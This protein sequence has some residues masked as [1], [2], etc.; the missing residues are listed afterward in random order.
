MVGFSNLANT[1]I[2]GLSGRIFGLDAQF[3]ADAVIMAIAMLVLFTLLSF[4]LF[5]PVRDFLKKRQE[6]VESN[7]NNA[8]KEKE[9][10]E[11][12][13]A[14]YNDKLLN[15]EKE[16]DEILS[17]TRK[18]AMKRENQIVDDAKDEA[19]RIIAIA[20]KEAELEKSRVKDEF[21]KRSLMS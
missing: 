21:G 19:A 20:S 15:V 13:K 4:L 12:L 6:Y 3:L 8:L 14:E 10:A 17:A 2:L 9:E 7:I 16:A 5:N 1:G 18:K 11:K